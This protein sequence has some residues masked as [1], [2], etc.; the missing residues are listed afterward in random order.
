MAKNRI[1]RYFEYR[2]KPTHCPKC[3]YKKWKTVVKGKTYKCRQ[4]GYEREN[5]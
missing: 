4:C 1:K 3:G 5:K 2:E